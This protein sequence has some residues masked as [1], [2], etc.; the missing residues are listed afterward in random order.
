MKKAISTLLAAGMC[1]AVLAG[2]GEPT[3]S[4]AALSTG[5]A[6]ENTPEFGS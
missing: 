2:C 6:T 5:T 3:S 1:L 4:D